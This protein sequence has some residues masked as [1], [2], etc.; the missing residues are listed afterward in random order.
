MV[1][2]QMHKARAALDDLFS[3][4]QTDNGQ[5]K[6]FCRDKAILMSR[7]EMTRIAHITIE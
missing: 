4:E 7:P 1:Y 3:P 2:R 6:G 5:D